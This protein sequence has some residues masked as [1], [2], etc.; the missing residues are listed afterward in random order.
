MA[1]PVTRPDEFRA[2]IEHQARHR[3]RQP[4]PGCG[5]CVPV[6]TVDTTTADDALDQVSARLDALWDVDPARG[7]DT[8]A[9][10]LEELGFTRVPMPPLPGTPEGLARLDAM[11]AHMGHLTAG[12]HVPGCVLCRD[13]AE[14]PAGQPGDLVHRAAASWQA[15]IDATAQPQPLDLAALRDLIDRAGRMPVL[16]LR[17]SPEVMRVLAA[18]PALQTVLPPI[19]IA[20]IRVDPGMGATQWALFRDGELD[21]LGVIDA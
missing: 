20:D 18:R 7:S 13:R 10:F 8:T 6:V 17:V 16:E 4:V 5:W 19:P 14:L 11:D 12:Q 3:G 15:A 2:W 21:T 9:G 1:Q